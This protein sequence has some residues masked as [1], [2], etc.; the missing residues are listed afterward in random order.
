MKI[1][2]DD[3]IGIIRP[4]SLDEIAEAVSNV[5]P[6]TPTIEKSKL[7]PAFVELTY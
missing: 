5:T 1:Y 4:S 3:G 6:I 2:A 7:R